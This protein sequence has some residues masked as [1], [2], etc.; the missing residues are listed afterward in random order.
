MSINAQAIADMES[1][2]I[3]TGELPVEPNVN[4]GQ[5][6]S[7][8]TNAHSDAVAT[9]LTDDLKKRL[10]SPQTVYKTITRGVESVTDMEMVQD[11]IAT[12]DA[13]SFANAE[14]VAMTFESF[15]SVVSLKEYTKTPSKV[16]LAFTNRFMEQQ[17]K[18]RKEAVSSELEK[19]LNGPLEDSRE[20]FEIYCDFY[21]KNLIED[22]RRFQFDCSDWLKNRHSIP[23]Q[24]FQVGQ[25]FM[26]FAT[27][28]LNEIPA[29]FIGP[30]NTALFS[31]A[32]KNLSDAAN[33]G[34][35][36][37]AL[38][39][40]VETNG[41]LA[42]FTNPQFA[43]A[44]AG[45]PTSALDFIRCFS[46]PYLVEFIGKVEETAEEALKTLEKLQE[47][48]KVDPVD[49]NQVRDFVVEN[50]STIHEAN[51]KIHYYLEL[52]EMLR[53]LY[54]NVSVVLDYFTVEK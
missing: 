26:N 40:I 25:D 51:E 35:H 54:P 44:Q 9:P 17:I 50:G 23:G 8:I 46:K 42:D 32:I 19:F 43:N 10:L 15:K 39:E 13:I 6:L 7:V 53:G 45:K 48:A 2:G 20:A 41:S 22:V 4:Q 30:G 27:V 52:M 11:S 18:L 38:L 24:I 31:N 12:A 29:E 5:D 3:L 36:V 37:K 14:E 49:F 1:Q 16:N 21:G 34:F 33:N 47:N 28:A